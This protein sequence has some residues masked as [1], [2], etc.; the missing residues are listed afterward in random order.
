[1]PELTELEYFLIGLCA[2]G[3]MALTGVGLLSWAALALVGAL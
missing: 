3:G 1:M 2:I